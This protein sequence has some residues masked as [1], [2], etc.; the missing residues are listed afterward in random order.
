MEIETNKIIKF[1]REKQ[2][3]SVRDF[4]SAFNEKL[5]NTGMSASMVS[6]LETKPYEPPLDLLFEC[7]ATYRND[8]R[9]NL[10]VDCI[11]AMYPDLVDSGIITFQLPKILE[12]TQ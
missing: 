7:I 1:Y 2:N 12:P 4:S 9:A 6:R 10:A 3:L 5:I 8:W 11:R